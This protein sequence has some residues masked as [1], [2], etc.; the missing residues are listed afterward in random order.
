MQRLAPGE[1][2]A[3]TVDFHLYLLKGVNLADMS[4]ARLPA[5]STRGKR[6]AKLIEEED[7]DDQEFWNQEAWQ[8]EAVDD[9]YKS[10]TEEEDVFDSDFSEEVQWPSSD[11]LDMK[12]SCGKPKHSVHCSNNAHAIA[13]N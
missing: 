5:R 8:E 9:D 1:T 13:C 4:G 10:E 6:I 2:P 12:V 3:C 11:Q 7:E